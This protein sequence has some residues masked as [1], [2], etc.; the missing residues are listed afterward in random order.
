MQQGMQKSVH[1][2]ITI[3]GKKQPLLFKSLPL[4]K[5]KSQSAANALDEK[6]ISAAL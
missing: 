3:C 1:I 6:T 2:C 5:R 4:S